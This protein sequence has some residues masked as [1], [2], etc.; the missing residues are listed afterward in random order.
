MSEAEVKTHETFTLPSSVVTKIDVS[1]LVSEM[2][3]VDNDMTAMTVRS[4]A[5]AAQQ[6]QPA[7]GKAKG[8]NTRKPPNAT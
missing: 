2:E 4:K 8:K 1:R 7:P 3:R 5:G 6:P